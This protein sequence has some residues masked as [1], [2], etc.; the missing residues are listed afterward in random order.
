M[1]DLCSLVSSSSKRTIKNKQTLN[2]FSIAEPKTLLRQDKTLL[3]PR[4]TETTAQVF[5]FTKT[6]KNLIL[7]FKRNSTWWKKLKNNPKTNNI[8]KIG[9]T[10][11]F[12][13]KG[14]GGVASTHGASTS[15]AKGHGVLSAYGQSSGPFYKLPPLQGSPI[16]TMDRLLCAQCVVGLLVEGLRGRGVGLR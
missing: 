6:I 13:W 16:V 12:I 8:L 10:W 4:N 2:S 9:N 5:I 7:G 3:W 1:H 11:L 15:S 14:G